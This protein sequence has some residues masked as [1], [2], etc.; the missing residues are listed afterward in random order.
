MGN[1]WKQ[2]KLGEIAQKVTEKNINLEYNDVLT[3]SAERGII[4]QQNFFDKSIANTENIDKYYVVRP[5]DFV[6]NPRISNQ[7]PVG[8]INQNKLNKTGV[9]SPLYTVFEPL[10]IDCLF[11]EHFFKSTK[12]HPYMYLNG[13]TGAR[14]DRFAIK[15]GVFF[16]MPISVPSL[17]EQKKIGAF[18]E[19]ITDSITLHQ[20]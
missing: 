20:R 13:D 8:P 1:P 16:Q 15:D 4:D 7:A 9:M 19:S 6:Y 5:G 14:A 2:R 17:E 11:L 3:N 10:E 12:W 18:F